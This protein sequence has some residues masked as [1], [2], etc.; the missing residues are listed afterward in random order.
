MRDEARLFLEPLE[1]RVLL[2]GDLD[3]L[4]STAIRS[5]LGA[6]GP[7][8][9]LSSLDGSRTA[10][11]PH[12]A[13]LFPSD[14]EEVPIVSG[15]L[16]APGE[17]DRFTLTLTERRT[18][19]FDSL[20][21]RS[22]IRWSLAGPTGAVV[23]DRQFDQSDGV[24]L[25][26]SPVL[27]LEPGDYL[28]SVDG[29]GAATGSYAFRLLDL[30][31]GVA[32]TPGEGV[33]GRLAEADH[34]QVYRF[35]AAAGSSFFFQRNALGGAT[36]GG[37]PHWRLLG[38]DHEVIFNSA[39]ADVDVLTLPRAG[40][41]TL[42]IEG[43]VY[44]TGG[45]ITYGFTLHRATTDTAPL[46][47]G[48]TVAGEIERPGGR[49]VYTFSLPSSARVVF[50]SLVFDPGKT[51]SL[52]GPRGVEVAERRF[53][54][55]DSAAMVENPVLDLPA[56]S[57]TLTVDGTGANTG[58]YAFRLLDLA[59]AT[60]IAIDTAV[61]GTLGDAGAAGML[62][63]T[64]AAAPLSY[65][66]GATNRAFQTGPL[67]NH[68][69]VPDASSLRPTALTLEAWVRRDADTPNFAGVAMKSTSAAWAD[70][71][72]LFYTSDGFIN[73]F[74][75]NWNAT[76]VRASLPANEWTHVAGTYDGSRLRL[77]VDGVLA[78]ER[79]VTAPI[80]H[81]LAELRIGSSSGRDDAWRG[82]ID[83]VRLWSVARSAEEIA[84]LR[85]TPI[86]SPPP[87]LAGYWRFD[88]PS[89]AT[90]GDASGKGNNGR[91]TA[92]GRE[93]V[94]YRVDLARGDQV[95]FDATS[96]GA[97]PFW[98][99]IDPSG[100]QIF[101][102]H[103]SDVS[104]TI[105]LAGPYILLVEGQP[106]NGPGGAFGF[107]VARQ[108]TTTLPPPSGEPIAFGARVDGTLAAAGEIDSFVFTTIGP[109]RLWFDSLTDHS[110][111]RISLLGPRGA[112]FENCSMS[113]G[114]RL[115]VLPVAGAYQLSIASVAG[116]TG[117]YA[118]RLLDFAAPTSISVGTEVVHT[119][120]PNNSAALFAF[121]ATAGERFFFDATQNQ[122]WWTDW[123]LFDPFGRQVFWADFQDRV[124][125][126]MHDGRY[127]LVLDGAIWQGGGPTEFRFRLNRPLETSQPLALDTVI[128]GTIGQPGDAVIY[129]FLLADRRML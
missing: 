53:D 106:W 58:R 123:R 104:Q 27:L 103:F 30:A 42:L 56:G 14:A 38:P 118:F 101:A 71:Y 8:I 16:E 46:V 76:R 43:A 40:W 84:A 57:Y 87:A 74:V 113:E 117:P 122:T 78:A 109:T 82:A 61:S 20:T 65:P 86:A 102:Q 93:T 70:G 96:G 67:A 23:S 21:N 129:S 92:N 121:D 59:Q 124:E 51:W 50:D 75:N 112:E 77:Y 6:P 36:A 80:N 7:V 31:Q 41:Y 100:R 115:V 110:N 66:P 125:T 105:H 48:E 60:A 22:D 1:P 68:V 4:G 29:D 37:T 13:G 108:G 95:L 54:Q 91:F 32:V 126:L 11:A 111:F 44:N 19:Y 18:L 10:E 15:T 9:D 2:S 120:N 33:A 47:L 98:R 35:D 97:S 34:T 64:T 49:D 127:T 89:G 39:F 72:G 69:V 83:E 73:F 3:L 85:N 99:V 63:R 45:E 25:F 52:I 119:A 81:S 128:G 94:A 12:A 114:D 28:L 116:A 17:T 24:T 26:G 88:E 90:V 62:M 5:S 55:S 79:E 107:T